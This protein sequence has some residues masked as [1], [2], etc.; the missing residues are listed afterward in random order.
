MNLTELKNSAEAAKASPLELDFWREDIS[1]D[2]VLTLVK[3][4]IAAQ[5]LSARHMSAPL[6]D[7]ILFDD[8]YSL[9]QD[10]ETSLDGIEPSQDAVERMKERVK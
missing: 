5:A 3:I 6:A 1:P 4:A 10:L 9:L 8:V 2:D 7:V